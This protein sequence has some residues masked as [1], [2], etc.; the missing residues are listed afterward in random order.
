LGRKARSI[1]SSWGEAAA[2]ETI[3]FG[4]GSSKSSVWMVT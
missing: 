4:G 1:A 2:A 3:R